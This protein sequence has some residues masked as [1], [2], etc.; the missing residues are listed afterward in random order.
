MHTKQRTE[1][2][3]HFEK[4]FFKLKYRNI[5]LVTTNKRRNYLVS[6]SNYHTI[7]RFFRK[8]TS[9]RNEENKSKKQQAVMSRFINIRYQ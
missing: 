5:N 7:K 1:A 4:D 8:F 3:N 6:E 9:N 2:K